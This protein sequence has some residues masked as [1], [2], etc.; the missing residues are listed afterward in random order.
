MTRSA[1]TVRPMPT[2][3]MQK[4][5]RW[6]GHVRRIYDSHMTRIVLDMEVGVIPRGRPKIYGYHQKR[7]EEEWADDRPYSRTQGLE[8]GSTQGDPVMWKSLQGEKVRG[9][10]MKA[11]V[12]QMNANAAMLGWLLSASMTKWFRTTSITTI[13]NSTVLPMTGT[14]ECSINRSIIRS[15]ICMEIPTRLNR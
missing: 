15:N 12:R 14:D 9:D 2:P 1:A 8:N 6:Y 13:V 7:Y 3:L 11:T 4:R 5:L 10:L